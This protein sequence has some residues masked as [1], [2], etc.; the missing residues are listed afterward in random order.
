MAIVTFAGTRA[1]FGQKTN[2]HRCTIDIYK[3][4][5]M[6]E[7]RGP[8]SY[9][10]PLSI[11]IKLGMSIAMWSSCIVIIATCWNK[12]LVLGQQTNIYRH[13]REVALSEVRG[14]GSPT[15]PLSILV[16]LSICIDIWPGCITAIV[17][18]STG[19][20]AA[21][22]YKSIYEERSPFRSS[23]SWLPY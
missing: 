4:I 9:P 1:G 14:L 18:T 7:D 2:L 16:K 20:G 15:K 23:R 11:L 12:E 6:F 10:K 3:K 13:M 21:D 19:F 8:G 17:V 22:K 5:E